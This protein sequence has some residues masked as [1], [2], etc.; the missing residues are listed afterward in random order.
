[1]DSASVK[2]RMGLEKTQSRTGA[3]AVAFGTAH[4]GTFWSDGSALQ[5]DNNSAYTRVKLIE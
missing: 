5:L 3:A 2:F 1:M 4:K